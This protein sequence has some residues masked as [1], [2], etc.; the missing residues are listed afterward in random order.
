MCMKLSY[1]T[2]MGGGDVISNH[3]FFLRIYSKD[4]REM[5]I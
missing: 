5:D 2:Y 3:K 4:F 1:G